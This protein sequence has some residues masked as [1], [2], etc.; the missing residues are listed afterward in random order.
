L[1]VKRRPQLAEDVEAV[2]AQVVSGPARTQGGGQVAVAGAVDLLDPG[3]QPDD[4]FVAVGGREFPPRR[5]RVWVVTVRVGAV[6]GEVGG[7]VGDLPVQGLEPGQ[8]GGIAFEL[9]ADAGDQV[10]EFG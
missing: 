3:L 4:G 6:E 10:G 2:Q 9:V 5:G 1:E 8:D 7:Q